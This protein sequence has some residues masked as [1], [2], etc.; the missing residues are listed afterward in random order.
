[1]TLLLA[2][3]ISGGALALVGSYGAIFSQKGST[4]H[5]RAGTLFLYA[6]ILMGTTAVGVGLERDKVATGLGGLFVV[7]YVI[8]AV[9]TLR[10]RTPATAWLD[11]ACTL[12]A[13]V[14]VAFTLSDGM[15]V[16]LNHGGSRNGVPAGM[17][18]FI[19]TVAA[20][21]V[22][23]DLRVMFAGPRTGRARL[24][25][26][27]WR[28]CFAAFFASG[29]FY[30]GQMQAIPEPLRILPLLFVLALLPLGVMGY[31]RFRL[32]ARRRDPLDHFGERHAALH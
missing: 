6:M 29:S 8:T 5:R 13:V 19:G 3:H 30:L 18:L 11:R 23:G 1:M 17:I 27:L 12:L 7:Y 25:R 15:D 2:S 28:M 16:L 9:T 10:A 4:L 21:A 22:V 26:H 31:W 14:L 20:L 24:V 32:R